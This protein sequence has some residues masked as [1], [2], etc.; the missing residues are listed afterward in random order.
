MSFE[1]FLSIGNTYAA[2]QSYQITCWQLSSSTKGPFGLNTIP[3]LTVVIEG[4]TPQRGNQSRHLL[5]LC[6]GIL[7]PGIF[8]MIVSIWKCS[9]AASDALPKAALIFL[10]HKQHALACSIHDVK[11]PVPFQIYPLRLLKSLCT[12]SCVLCSSAA[13]NLA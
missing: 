1:D 8:M 6:Y 10:K 5:W 7:R 11:K 3:G 4:V 12:A 13:C 9:C 2:W